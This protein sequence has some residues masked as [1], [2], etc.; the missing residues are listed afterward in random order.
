MMPRAANRI[1]HDEALGQ[2]GTIV[3]AGG[4]NREYL[5]A[6]ANEENWLTARVPEQHRPIWDCRKLNSLG[7]IRPAQ[8]AF[9]WAHWVPSTPVLGTRELAAITHVSAPSQTTCSAS[10]RASSMSPRPRFCRPR[11]SG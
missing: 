7:E 8:F 6:A 5:N 10:C 3:R 2:R 9:Y 1:S 11:V 4:A